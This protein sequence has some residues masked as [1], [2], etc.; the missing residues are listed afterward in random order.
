MD[1]INN[2]SDQ[3][4]QDRH[5]V[6]S[7]WSSKAL[8]PGWWVAVVLTVIH[9]KR[10]CIPF[11]GIRNPFLVPEFFRDPVLLV[12]EWNYISPAIVRHCI[13]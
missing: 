1:H 12:E 13:R 5:V 7:V 3:P 6:A 10:R 8:Y 4:Y 11:A 9:D 2:D